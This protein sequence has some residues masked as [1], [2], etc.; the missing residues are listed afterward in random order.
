MLVLRRVRVGD[1]GPELPAGRE[2]AE[3]A[4]D[5]DFF[6]DFHGFEVASDRDGDFGWRRF[7]ADGDGVVVDVGHE[8]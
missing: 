5:D 4:V 1:E 3:E 6:V 2:A 8:G 7:V